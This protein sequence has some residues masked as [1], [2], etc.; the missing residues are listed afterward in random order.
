MGSNST[1]LLSLVRPQMDSCVQFWT[2]HFKKRY[3]DRDNPEPRKKNNDE[4][5][6]QVIQGKAERQLG[7]FSL[8]KGDKRDKEV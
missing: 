2:L 1:I 8:E 7:I 3:T 4:V 5:G 6:V